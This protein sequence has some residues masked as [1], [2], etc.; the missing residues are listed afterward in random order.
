MS[1]ISS[2]YGRTELAQKYFP[3]VCPDHAWRKLKM[4]MQEFPELAPL[5]TKPRRTFT[6]LE[7]GI[8]FNTLGLPDS[9]QPHIKL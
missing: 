1:T 7:A 5:T 8:I 9:S 2:C 4:L 6:P 3:N